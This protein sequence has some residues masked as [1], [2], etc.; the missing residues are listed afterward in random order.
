MDRHYHSQ[1]KKTKRV[2]KFENTEGV[3][4]SCKSK[5]NRQHNGQ[6]KKMKREEKFE[7]TEGVSEYTNHCTTC[8]LAYPFGIF[9]LFFSFHL[10]VWRYRRGKRVHK[11]LHHW[12]NCLCTRLPL[13]YLQTFLLFS[14]FCFGRCVE[15]QDYACKSKDRQHNSQKKKDNS[16]N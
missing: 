3:I 12:C 5:K 15:G 1:K 9:K 14:S 10:F 11:P 2:E 6:S 13:R 8:V 7:D 16:T 4:R